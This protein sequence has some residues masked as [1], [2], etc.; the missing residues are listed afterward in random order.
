LHLALDA[1]FGI[2]TDS[3]GDDDD[4]GVETVPSSGAGVA[5]FVLL[6]GNANGLIIVDASFMSGSSLTTEYAEH[7][8]EH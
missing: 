5:P 3:S 2:G 8:H 6:Y 1:I 4:D 7:S